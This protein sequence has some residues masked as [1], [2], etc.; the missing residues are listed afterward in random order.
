[1]GHDVGDQLLCL[2]A[3]RLT[4]VASSHSDNNRKISAVRLGGDEFVLIVQFNKA[5]IGCEDIIDQV[6]GS[7]SSTYVMNDEP[8]RISASI[9]CSR[10]PHDSEEPEVLV[11]QADKAMYEAKRKGK[12]KKKRKSM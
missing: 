8:V 2:V 1:M 11:K 3:A 7:L 5:G 9:G 4:S 6:L 10:F 12:N